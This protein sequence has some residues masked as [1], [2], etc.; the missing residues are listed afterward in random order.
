VLG[1][2]KYAA[3][4]LNFSQGSFR[5]TSGD[6]E[7][8][9]PDYAVSAGFQGVASFSGPLIASRWFFTGKNRT[10]LYTVQYVYLA[11]AGLGL[12]L[13]I[14]FRF[15]HLPEITEEALSQGECS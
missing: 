4:R 14:L 9:L 8:N 7:L 3:S 15:C 10:S 12:V 6:H 11:V 13:N 2:P 5:L 1:S